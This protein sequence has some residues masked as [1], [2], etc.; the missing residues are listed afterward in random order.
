M[1]QFPKEAGISVVHRV[2]TGSG[3]PPSFLDAWN[4]LLGINRPE[5]TFI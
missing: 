4:V 2:Q 5:G 1:V 3:A